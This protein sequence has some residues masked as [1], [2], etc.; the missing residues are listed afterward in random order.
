MK[1]LHILTSNRFSGAE[2]VVCQIIGMFKNEQDI[3]MA[4]CSPDGS[5]R[6][7]LE[8]RD[9]RFLP[10]KKLN[11]KELKA[12]IREYQPDIVHA[13]DM[14]ASFVA[15]KA[16]GK[17]PMI[18]HVH[19]N[20][21]NARGITLKSLAFLFAAKKAKHIFWVSQ[22]SYD[23]YSFHNLFKKKSTILYNI[24]D[25][26]E[27]YDKMKQD[28]N[29]YRYDITY[30]GRL[31]YQKNPCRLIKVLSKVLELSP[32]AKVGIVGTGDL[33]GEVKT[34]VKEFG[35]EKHIEFLGF[36]SNPLKM[37]HDSKVM[38]MTSRW[39]GTPMC[40]LEAMAL[41]VPIVSTPTDGLK[42]LIT[43]GVN[44]FLSD[45]DEVLAEKICLLIQDHK[46]RKE[47]SQ[48]QIQKAEKIN[49]V[50]SYKYKLLKRYS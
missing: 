14:R 24:I 18:S 2:N 48:A 39:E 28:E 22:S 5:I 37:L 43:D 13:H 35:I 19:V 45:D 6:A 1:V 34:L 30:V 20:A 26:K 8:E 29:S 23:G 15:A 21:A 50:E 42:E 11:K 33:E 27:L 3:E 9:I 32:S 7:A 16:V 46:L 40:A 38:V 41:G 25:I 49:D 47:M 17:I 10:I 44:G 31:A 36:Q 12:V 4:Y